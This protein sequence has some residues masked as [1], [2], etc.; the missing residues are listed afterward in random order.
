MI[1]FSW[2]F[3]SESQPV[4]QGRKL[5]EWAQE[6][7]FLDPDALPLPPADAISVI[8]A[9][10]AKALPHAIR[11]LSPD[12]RDKLKEKCGSLI[13][14]FNASQ[15]WLTFETDFFEPPPKWGWAMGIFYA[16][17]TNAR[18]AIPQLI[19]LLEGADGDASQGAAEAL[20]QIGAESIPFLLNSLVSTNR[21][22]V[23]GAIQS[24][25]MLGTNSLAAAPVLLDYLRGDF[26]GLGDVCAMALLKVAPESPE[27][28]A[29]M[30]Q[31][32]AASYPQPSRIS[33]VMIE[34]LGTNAAS[35]APL[36]IAMIEAD[37]SPLGN[38]LAV[39]ALCQVDPIR[40]E[41]YA[42]RRQAA[43]AAWQAT[44]QPASTS[45]FGPYLP[46]NADTNALGATE[47]TH[48]RE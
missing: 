1:F 14:E 37:E 24:L 27:F 47:V 39:R 23:A 36:L 28:R 26:R 25:T 21:Q 7:D 34:K 33:F 45:W 17:G 12:P 16:L 2:L 48:A 30:I 29:A 6:V 32:F 13:G 42:T 18:P 19:A 40:G 35:M 20:S 9:I 22:A 44:N 5:S 38:G 15:N 41:F 31:R 46:R 4:F 10:G 8:Q 11:W 3:S 43:I